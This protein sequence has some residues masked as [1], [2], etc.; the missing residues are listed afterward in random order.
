MRFRTLAICALTIAGLGAS[1][2]ST[3]AGKILWQSNL[4]LAINEAKKTHK[5][6][7]A[8]FYTD[9]CHWCKK[10]DSDTYTDPKVIQLSTR[11]VP[12][13]IDA[14]K[15]GVEAAKK[16]TVNGYPTI[17]FI[18][19]DGAVE[20]KIGGYMPAGSFADQL[21]FISAS[22]TDFPALQE[23]IQR[24]PS[25]VEAAARLARIYAGRGDETR[26]KLYIQMAEKSDPDNSKGMLTK[27]YNALGDYYQGEQKFDAA[28]VQFHK[29]AKTGKLPAD[30]SYAYLSAAQCYLALDTP[31]TTDA[32]SDLTT[33]VNLTG[34]SDNDRQQAQAMI[35]AIKVHVN[36]Q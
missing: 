4:K 8:D 21:D 27:A 35:K 2:P 29:A 33:V 22:H 9:W 23:R 20:G 1:R 7:M 12:V 28:L 30:V 5:L 31:D 18:T 25:D 19:E 6:I 36:G 3:A 26:T 34:V 17:L 13:K 10:L 15:E 24:D 16:Y 32:L 14:E 11:F